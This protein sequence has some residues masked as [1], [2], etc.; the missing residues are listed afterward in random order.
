MIQQRAC[1]ICGGGLHYDWSEYHRKKN[2]YVHS[3]CDNIR[4]STKYIHDEADEKY[5]AK[6]AGF[7]YVIVHPDWLGLSKIGFSHNPKGR[8]SQ[9]NTWCPYNKYYVHAAIYSD[10]AQALEAEVHKVL[11]SRDRKEVGEWFLINQWHAENLIRRK[12]R[13][14]EARE[15]GNTDLRYQRHAGRRLPDRNRLCQSEFGGG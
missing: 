14:K 6:K 13:E 4:R 2:W 5:D 3:K 12:K 8:V 10:D 7:V 15:N 11:T 9:A 1:I